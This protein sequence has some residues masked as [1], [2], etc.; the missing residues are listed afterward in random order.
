MPLAPFSFLC[1]YPVASLL[2]GIGPT[3]AAVVFENGGAMGEFFLPEGFIRRIHGYSK[4]CLRVSFCVHPLLLCFWR[5]RS[6]RVTFHFWMLPSILGRRFG[7]CQMPDVSS[8]RKTLR[9][10]RQY[11]TQQTRQPIC[12]YLTPETRAT[13]LFGARAKR[14]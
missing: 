10:I 9:Q 8:L 1:L 3:E 12:Q 6:R 5:L 2:F 11:V 4:S 13:Q 7:I 14:F